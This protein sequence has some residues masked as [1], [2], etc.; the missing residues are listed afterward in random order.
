MV[1][2]PSSTSTVVDQRRSLPVLRGALPIFALAL[3]VRLVHLLSITDIGF[4][5]VPLSDAAVYVERARSIVAGDWLGDERFVHAPS[6]AWFLALSAAVTNDLVWSPRVVQILLGSVSCCLIAAL[7]AR[8]FDRTVGL[9]AG[10]LVALHPAAVFHDALIQKT[11]LS[12]FFAALALERTQAAVAQGKA[13][14]WFIAGIVWG[15][16]VLTRQNLLALLPLPIIWLWTAGSAPPRYGARV[17]V[18]MLFLLTFSATVSPWVIRNRIVHGGLLLTTPN[19]GQNFAMGNHIDAT[20]TYLPHRRGYAN[21]LHEQQAWVRQAEQAAGRSL[22]AQEV[23]DHYLRAGLDFVRSHPTSFARIC[24]WKWLLLWNTYEP[25]DTEDYYL[26]LEWSRVLRLLDAIG[27][28]GGLAPLALVGMVFAIG[29]WPRLWPLYAW[30]VLVA[31]SVA[32]FVVF[33]RYRIPLLPA[34]APFAAHGICALFRAAR[35][36]DRVRLSGAIGLLLAAAVPANW[37]LLSARTV[38]VSGLVNHAIALAD[39]QRYDEAL[40]TLDRARTLDSDNVDVAY[41]EATVREERNELDA[42]QRAVEQALRGDAYYGAAWRLLG[43]LHLAL[44]RP[45]A[46]RQCYEQAIHVEPFQAQSYVGLGL[47]A[48]QVGDVVSALSAFNRAIELDARNVDARVN[49]GI[50]L[51]LDGRTEA[52]LIAFDQALAITRDHPLALV[53]RALALLQLGRVDEARRGLERAFSQADDDPDIAIN[54]ALVQQ[55]LGDP[56]AARDTLLRGIAAR[57]AILDGTDDADTGLSRMQR[58][59][60]TLR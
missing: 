46:A 7:G 41:V 59:L 49:R 6:Y 37:P 53:N 35:A 8:M 40:S 55:R 45:E 23:S 48:A 54:L 29:R 27:H 58:L 36:H 22:S 43:K 44:G 1:E 28:Y 52:S 47:V 26:Y 3:G 14:R 19:L 60:E 11:T 57:R 15:L 33:G 18:A 38:Q 25:P 2:S 4:F 39:S 34:V 56:A 32:A 16:L 50:A 17:G 51:L 31:L 13:W 24:V 10:V 20:G 21:G 30:V 9:I 5:E 12:L 42:A